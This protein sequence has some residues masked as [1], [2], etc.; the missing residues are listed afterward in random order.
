MSDL[1]LTCA[2]FLQHQTLGSW[3][4]P[5]NSTLSPACVSFT[6]LPGW[7]GLT[8]KLGSIEHSSISCGKVAHNKIASAG[9]GRR[10]DGALLTLWLASPDTSWQSLPWHCKGRAAS[11]QRACFCGRMI[12]AEGALFVLGMGWLRMHAALTTCSAKASVAGLL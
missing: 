8:C 5:T 7:Q 1:L 12:W 9:Q 6:F 4:G 2:N 3:A 10:H 11:E